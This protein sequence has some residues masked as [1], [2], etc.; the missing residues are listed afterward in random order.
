MA[1]LEIIKAPDPRLKQKAEDVV[2]F[3][4]DLSQFVDD[5]FETMYAAEG[6]GL[7]ATQVGVLKRVLVLDVE[8]GEDGKG[9]PQEFI[10]PKIVWQSEDTKPYQ[11]GCLSFPGNFAE[12]RRPDIIEVKFVNRKGE[13]QKIKADGLLSIC[14]QHE[15]DHLNGV[16][17]VDHLSRLRR[18]IILN[19]LKKCK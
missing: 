9:Q 18:N 14:L 7:A 1:I 6:I 10:N 13:S 19:K 17:F 4:A 2:V 12:V 11:E 3:D 15:I 16:T 8:Q 5:M